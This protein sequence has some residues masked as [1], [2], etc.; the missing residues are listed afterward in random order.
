MTPGVSPPAVVQADYPTA[1]LTTV[2]TGGPV[3]ITAT[4]A[5]AERITAAGG[6][7]LRFLISA[8]ASLEEL[9]LLGR[10]GGALGVAEHQLNEVLAIFNKER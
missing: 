5:T 9:F 6:G 3:V 1:R 8:H 4:F 10:L 7:A 2:G